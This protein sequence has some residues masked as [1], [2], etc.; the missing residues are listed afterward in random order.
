M[1]V[2]VGVREVVLV[3]RIM[4]CI[5]GCNIVVVVTVVLMGCCWLCGLHA[6]WI[7][8]V[9]VV[10]LILL[11]CVWEIVRDSYGSVACTYC[12]R[13]IIKEC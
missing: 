13:S 4:G 2:V 9:I 6:Q 7:E 11:V 3:V 1:L 8:W 10:F 5:N 12:N